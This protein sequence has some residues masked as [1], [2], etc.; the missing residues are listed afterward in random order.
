MRPRSLLADLGPRGSAGIAALVLLA[1]LRAG[2]LL[3]IAQGIAG[4]LAALA[5]SPGVPVADV[6][7]AAAGV[8]LRAVASWG[9]TTVASALAAA[10]KRRWRDR[11]VRHVAENGTIGGPEETLLATRGLDDLDGYL[12]TVL[13]TVVAAVVIPVALG[14]RILVADPLS[15]L[16]VAVTV[17]LVPVF[18]ILIGMHSR[19]RAEAASAALTRLAG[20]LVELAEG[21]PVLVGLG[22]AREQTEALA[23]IQGAY[24]RRLDRAVRT[25]L[26]SALALELIATLSV[27]VVAVTLGIRLLSG[28]IGL[29][30]ALLVLLLAPDCFTALRDVGAA[31]H[32]AQDGRTA[33]ARIRELVGRRRTDV[34]RV[35]GPVV[36]ADLSVRH[37]GRGAVAAVSARPPARGI[38]LLDGPSGAG[39]STLLDAIGGVT[40]DGAVVSGRI[41][42]ISPDRLA[43]ARQAPRFA[44]ATPREELASISAG[45]AALAELGLAHL[46]DAAILRLSPG[47]QRRVAVARALARFDAGADTVILDEPTAHLDEENAELVRAAIDR[48]R[49]AGLI[50]V[51]SHDPRL[52]VLADRVVPVRWTPEATSIAP[53]A[54]ASSTDEVVGRPQPDV[55]VGRTGGRGWAAWISAALL[56]VTASGMSLALTGVSGWLIVRASA[57]PAIMYLLVAI[58]GVRFF[59]LGRAVARYAERV[60]GHRAALQLVDELRLRLWRRLA[61]LGAAARGAR[62][63]GSALELLVTLPGRLLELLP[64]IATPATAGVVSV[65]GA[66]VAVVLISPSSLPVGVL[67]ATTALVAPVLAW[68]SDRRGQRERVA[69]DGELTRRLAA[70][71]GAAVDLRMNG[72]TDAPARELLAVTDRIERA[73][74]RQGRRVATAGVV[75]GV[76]TGLA[77]V[78]APLLVQRADLAAVVSLLALACLEPVAMAAAGAQR[79]PALVAVLTR[80]RGAFERPSRPDGGRVAPVDPSR[81]DLD[82]LALAWGTAPPVIEH[83]DA[84]LRRPGWVA[85]EGPSGSGKTTLVTALLG[86][87]PPASGTMRVDAVDLGAID[88]DSWR[89]RIAWCPQE[90]HVFDSTLRA[91]LLLARSRTDPVRED[92]AR[93]VL[94]EVGLAHLVEG[95]AGLDLRV[96]PHG[97]RLSGGE[98]QR[99]AV[100]RALLR[101]APV[102]VLDEP[103]AHLDERTADAMMADLRAATADRL[104]VLVSHRRADRELADSVIRLGAGELAAV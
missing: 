97:A 87:L 93:A 8:V 48:R 86:D 1:G 41:D 103:T 81:I 31:Y 5:A 32:Q 45:V 26:L 6:A 69:D 85:V 57:E 18:M 84:T 60:A 15:A 98:R 61:D 38:V 13:P 9:T 29:D 62:D 42:G 95:P 83:L 23:R 16:I 72:M 58:V 73:D 34:P 14:L 68:A 11:L 104:V 92:E 75:A 66:A 22:R 53:A 40:P 50:L 37:P 10:A 2:G 4:A 19:E 65:L 76:G 12:G 25:A 17:P 7:V 39:K 47:E 49:R 96:G 71:T 44:A 82:D 20:H 46:A 90:A 101:G 51:A 30:A 88:R 100:A 70:F 55:T 77:A 64:R 54:P 33:L 91:N 89:T 24:R 43:A 56:G 102:L 21:L 74:R 59:G 52:R 99:L 27:A 67:L 3:L 36:I 79:I 94:T 78:L 63:S 80:L 28:S 35:A